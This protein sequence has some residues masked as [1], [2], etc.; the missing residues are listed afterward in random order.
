[1]RR[2]IRGRQLGDSGSTLLSVVVIMLV[3]M[4][5]ALTT[6]AVTVNTTRSLVSTRTIASARAAADAGLAALVA[7]ARRNNDFCDLTNGEIDRAP[8]APDYEVSSGSCDAG[9]KQVT[10]TS[11]G[12]PK[13]SA[14][15][16]I[17]AT[18]SYTVPLVTGPGSAAD[19][20]LVSGKGADLNIS[21][22][23]VLEGGDLELATGALDCNVQSAFSG[24]VTVRSGAVKLNNNCAI[25]G[26]VFVE[27]GAFTCN[28]NSTVGGDVV[29]RNGSA[30]ITN[31]CSIGGSLFVENGN[32][33]CSSAGV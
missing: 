3:L 19:G 4:V 8:N 16:T 24:D 2:L 1:M 18:Y 15:A 26:N 10:F 9:A 20:A 6:A 32:Y 17:K 30:T 23:Q 22:I 7:H 29:V 25:G 11:V 5:V 33:T 13:S 21:S 28:N 31:N 14:P 12:H 27:N